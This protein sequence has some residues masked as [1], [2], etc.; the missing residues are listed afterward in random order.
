MER[1]YVVDPAR[2]PLPRPLN[3]AHTTASRLHTACIF[4]TVGCG[5][6]AFSCTYDACT[7]P[8]MSYVTSKTSAPVKP[9]CKRRHLVIGTQGLSPRTNPRLCKPSGSVIKRG[10]DLLPNAL[11]KSWHVRIHYHPYLPTAAYAM[12]HQVVM[13]GSPPPFYSPVVPLMYQAPTPRYC[14]G[15]LETII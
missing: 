5:W 3:L 12:E 10:G 9:P 6:G 14:G 13:P 15:C 7:C 2:H 11:L 4:C 1:V 8:Y